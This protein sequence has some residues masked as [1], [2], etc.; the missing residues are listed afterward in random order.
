MTPREPAGYREPRRSG[1]GLVESTLPCRL[2]GIFLSLISLLAQA[3]S[4]T[5]GGGAFGNVPIGSLLLTALG[6]AV[7]TAVAAHFRQKSQNAAGK[8][9]LALQLDSEKTL[10]DQRLAAEQQRLDAQLAGERDRLQIQL[11]NARIDEL[12]AVFENATLALLQA[13]NALRL[14]LYGEPETLD[15][16]THLAQLQANEARI[17][18]RLGNDDA[19]TQTYRQAA[20]KWADAVTLAATP[21]PAVD[22]ETAVQGRQEAIVAA[23]NEGHDLSK[24]FN[25]RAA[26][27]LGLEAH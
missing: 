21:S 3:P 2:G 26:A 14:V 13:T 22:D 5:D 15:T 27:E 23:F 7:V 25:D 4:R 1:S 17:A 20:Q 24:R 12:R 8:D 10:L 16:R 9:R 18:V 11:H 6:A 19:I